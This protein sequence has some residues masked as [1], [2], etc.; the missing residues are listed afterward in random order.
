VDLVA[1]TRQVDLKRSSFAHSVVFRR[2]V[3]DVFEV[4]F[5]LELV[6][7]TQSDVQKL[8]NNLSR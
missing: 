5:E 4:D 7:N 1:A 6:G 8:L 2:I 3:V